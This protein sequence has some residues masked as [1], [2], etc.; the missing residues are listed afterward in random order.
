M[1]ENMAV[2]A[3][4]LWMTDGTG[5]RRDGTLLHLKEGNHLMTNGKVMRNPGSKKRL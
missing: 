3:G 2:R 4:A 1:T 5:K